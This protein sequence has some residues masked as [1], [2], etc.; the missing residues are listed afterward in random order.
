MSLWCPLAYEVS[1]PQAHAYV[2]CDFD[3]FPALKSM[4]EAAGWYVFRTPFI[5]HKLNSG[6]VPLPDRGPRRS[7]ETLLYAIKGNKPVTHIYPDVIPVQGDDNLGHGAQKPVALMQNLLQ[8]SITPGS[9]VLDAFAG[10]GPVLE[11]AHGM[12]CYAT[13]LERDPGSYG[14]ILGRMAKLD[15]LSSGELF[16]TP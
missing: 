14:I 13:L 8:R 6:R 12:K 5:V 16:P 4:M 2:F 1:A 9:R 15:S 10:T 11:A 7:Y 3:N